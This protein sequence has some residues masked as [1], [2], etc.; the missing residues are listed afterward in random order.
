MPDPDTLCGY[1][2]PDVRSS[3]RT[4][5]DRRDARAAHRWTAELVATP[6]AVGSLWSSYWMAWAAAQGAGSA[7]P[8]LPIL[9]KQGWAEIATKAQEY[10][11]DWVAFRN[12]SDVRASA[13]DMTIRLLTQSRQTPVVWPSKELILYDVGT[14]R[15]SSPP[16]AADGPVVMAVWQRNEDAMEFRMMAGRWLTFL[17]SGDLRAALSAVAWTLLP[18]A[19][20]GLPQ[21]LKMAERGPAS[22][23]TAKARAS[24]LWFWLEVGRQWLLQRGTTVHRGWHTM[25][26]AISEAF[27]Q[28]YKRW[29]A[30]D[31]MRLLLAWILQLRASLLPQP[32]ELWTA[33]P[34]HINGAEIDLSYKEVAAEL[35]DPVTAI[36]VAEKKPGKTK[37]DDGKKAAL[38]RAEAKMAEADAA[39]YAALGFTPEDI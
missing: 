14:M 25:H 30:P 6:G 23:G 5:I 7:S 31:R 4:S 35:A 22:V 19:Q 32:A 33:P 3:L 38:T 26:V 36:Q 24:P 18:T 37:E 27:R 20:Q 2:L 28:N 11:G 9:L 8:T 12:D 29:T 10:G 1:S 34:I 15:D 21:P 39:V 16:S 13:A 17:E